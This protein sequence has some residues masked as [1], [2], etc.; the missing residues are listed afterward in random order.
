MRGWWVQSVICSW[1]DSSGFPSDPDTNH[2]VWILHANLPHSRKR[3]NIKQRLAKERDRKRERE[4]E[5]EREILLCFAAYQVGLRTMLF[6]VMR[7]D[8]LKLQWQLI[9]AQSDNNRRHLDDHV[10]ICFKPLTWDVEILFGIP[11]PEA[12]NALSWFLLFF[13]LYLSLL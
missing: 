13:N 7:V 6:L 4:R 12:P 8:N 3:C 5:R 1:I 2:P 10:T 9:P 11:P